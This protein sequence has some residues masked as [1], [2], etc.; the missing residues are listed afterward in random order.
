MFI[1]GPHGAAHQIV[2]CLVFHRSGGVVESRRGAGGTGCIGLTV[3]VVDGTW[4]A[5]IRVAVRG[6]LAD[7]LHAG[8][9]VSPL[10]GSNDE[11]LYHNCDLR[12]DDLSITA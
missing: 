9:H 1:V 6:V 3:L 7:A 4:G 10:W 11:L 2:I 12:D 5:G 8:I